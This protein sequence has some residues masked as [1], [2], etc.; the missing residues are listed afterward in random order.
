MV[1]IAADRGGDGQAHGIAQALL[2]SDGAVANEFAAASQTFHAERGDT[3][4]VRFGQDVSFKAAEGR[5]AAIERHL[6]GI[7]GK[8]VR[9]HFQMDFGIFVAGESDEAD[10]ALLLGGE[11]GFGSAVRSEDQVGIVFVDHFVNLPEIEMIGLQAA[12]RFFQHAHGDFLIA[13]VG[14]DLGHHES[15][16]PLSFQRFAEALFAEAVVIFPGVVE[17][18]GRRDR[19]LWRQFPLAA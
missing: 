14:A 18:V 5:V 10:F 16:I 9:Q 15:L 3:A 2:G 4:T 1:S 19:R 11:Q 12:K 17:K 13:S 8:I 6:H 7:E